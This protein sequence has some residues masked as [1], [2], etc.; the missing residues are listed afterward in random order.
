MD[1]GDLSVRAQ[2]TTSNIAIS[3]DGFS[4]LQEGNASASSG[5]GDLAI[6]IG[7]GASALTLEPEPGSAGILSTFNFAFADGASSN[8]VSGAG[9][10]E[11][12]FADGTNSS[13]IAALGFLDSAIADGAN[14]TAHAGGT[15]PVC[16]GLE[17]TG[18]GLGS[19]DLA[20][21]FGD[22][23]HA[24]ATSGSFVTTIDPAPA[25]AVAPSDLNPFE[26]LFGTAGINTWTP[27]A[28]SFLASSDPTL[29]AS[30]DTSVDNFWS[31]DDDPF[32]RLVAEFVPGA[33]SGTEG[34]GGIGDLAL[35]LDYTVFASGLAPTLDPAISEFANSLPT[36]S[37]DILFW[38]F[39]PEDLLGLISLG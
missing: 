25:A 26:D 2:T 27:S 20:A 14:S 23:L 21:A 33:F 16:V 24:T 4:L 12:A 11:S 32:T 19:F 9:S 1:L 35:G 28:D 31:A 36:L 17:C 3:V 18:G 39:F 13:A 29:A 30:L 8:A 6:A 38:L 7:N 15:L 10:F 37:S 34:P 22:N 5:I